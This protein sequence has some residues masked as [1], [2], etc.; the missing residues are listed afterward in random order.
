MKAVSRAPNLIQLPQIIEKNFVGKKI[1]ISALSM[2]RRFFCVV[3]SFNRSAKIKSYASIGVYYT[4]IPLHF[5]RLKMLRGRFDSW[6]CKRKNRY[7]PPAIKKIERTLS[8]DDNGKIYNYQCEI[9]SPTDWAK[10]CG[11]LLTFLMAWT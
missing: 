2:G 5:N 9:N 4:N 3:W 6:R 11:S 8:I 10:I 7:S 1:K